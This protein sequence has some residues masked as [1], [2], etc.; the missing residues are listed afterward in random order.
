MS[1]LRRRA[2]SAARAPRNL[3]G[4][5]ANPTS[6]ASSRRA[7]S[8]SE[9][10]PRSSCRLRATGPVNTKA[11]LTTRPAPWAHG[12]W[13][14]ARS[15]GRRSTWA[16]FRQRRRLRAHMTHAGRVRASPANL[17]SARRSTAII[18]RTRWRR[19]SA[20]STNSSR[21]ARPISKQ[22]SPRPPC[23]DRGCHPRTLASPSTR[24]RDCVMRS[25]GAMA[26]STPCCA[27]PPSSMLRARTTSF[28]FSI[29]IRR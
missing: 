11:F 5:C 22:S 26:S 3:A 6:Q 17:S 14:G 9:R 13:R 23:R 4:S 8:S 19:A 15:T 18:F 2:C 24:R 16:Y 25:Y 21:S 20:S 7:L 10:Q 1:S 12:I 29:R 27:G 28:S